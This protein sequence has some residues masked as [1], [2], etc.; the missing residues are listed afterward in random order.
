MNSMSAPKR[1]AL[2]LITGVSGLLL[3]AIGVQA[4]SRHAV[5]APVSNISASAS[6]PSFCAP[7]SSALGGCTP[8][9][10]QFAKNP[11]PVVVLPS[12]GTPMSRAGALSTVAGPSGIVLSNTRSGAKLTTW[13]TYMA[14]SGGEKTWVGHNPNQQVWL[15]AV[16]GSIKPEFAHGQ[17]FPWA[18]F[19]YDAG[20]G[21]PL[22][23]HA[24]PNGSWPSYFDSIQDLATR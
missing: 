12:G 21:F 1:A 8:T 2:A 13:E 10:L 16:S 15:V 19:V 14:A 3:T 22:A 4:L 18:V 23:T 17:V 24:G 6:P 5:V 7:E 11:P 9:E 20:T